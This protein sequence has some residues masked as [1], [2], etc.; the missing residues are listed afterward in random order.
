MLNRALSP[1]C[2]PDQ[3]PADRQARAALVVAR[4][5]PVPARAPEVAVVPEAALVPEAVRELVLELAREREPV[6]ALGPER[7]RVASALA[8]AEVSWLVPAVADAAA[9]LS[10]ASCPWSQPRLRPRSLR[11]LP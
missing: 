9:R 3:S 5:G 2:T 1:Q 6:R 8:P 7:V 10:S 4:E 11:S